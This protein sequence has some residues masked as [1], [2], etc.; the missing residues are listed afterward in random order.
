[1]L[2][3]N[4]FQ[5]IL[6]LFSIN[7]G[8]RLFLLKIKQFKTC[9]KLFLKFCWGASECQTSAFGCLHE[10]FECWNKHADVLEKRFGLLRRRVSECLRMVFGCLEANSDAQESIRI[11]KGLL[12]RGYPD[13]LKSIRI[14]IEAIRILEDSIR[15]STT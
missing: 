1:M 4:L 13:T 9:W 7:G 2:R 14:C 15:M 6:I 5:F 10:V 8:K 11:L 3:H 12:H